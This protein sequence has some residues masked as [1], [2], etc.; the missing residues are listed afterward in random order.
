MLQRRSLGVASAA[1]LALLALAAASCGD[2]GPA[3]AP[4]GCRPAVE[5]CNGVDDDCDGLVDED[6]G[7]V[8]CGTGPCTVTVP[9]CEGGAPVECRPRLPSPETCN[10][11][12]DDCDGAVDDGCECAAGAERPCFSGPA[13]SAGVGA[14]RAGVQRCEEG[15]WAAACAGEVLPAEE[16]CNGVDDDCDGKTDES[17]GG[18]CDTGLPG[19][20]ATGVRACRPEGEVCVAP[21]PAPEVCNGTDDDCDPATPDGAAEPW[22]GKPCDGPD[23]DACQEGVFTC[24][25]GAQ[26]CTDRTPTNEEL[27]NARDDD[28]DGLVDEGFVLDSNPPCAGARSI[29]SVRGDSGFDSVFQRDWPEAW[30]R[31]SVRDEPAVDRGFLSARVSLSTQPPRTVILEIDCPAC[32]GA[33]QRTLTVGPGQTGTL[34]VAKTD[35]PGADDSFE[36]LVHVAEPGVSQACGFWSLFVTGNEPVTTAAWTCP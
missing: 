16:T 34:V 22:F 26:A 33:P 6:A 30:L 31:I 36:M 24:A 1:L 15:R 18:A 23:A 13:G 17:A 12:D 20:C 2:D 21:A 8:T 4:P 28:C 19:A 14:C 3:A 9:D 25:G 7:E 32:G 27:C 35:V 5:I 10:G 11:V 29:G